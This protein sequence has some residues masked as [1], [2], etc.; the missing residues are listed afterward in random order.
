[1]TDSFATTVHMPGISPETV[2]ICLDDEDFRLPVPRPMALL[3][4][5]AAYAWR[6]LLPEGLVE[7]DTARMHERLRDPEDPMSWKRLHVVAQPLGLYLYGFPFFVAARALGTA[8]HYFTT[9]RMWSLCNIAIDLHRASA[10]DWCAAA[11]TWLS[12]QGGGKEEQRKAMWAELT[13]P[14]VL[15]MEA[16]GV[17]PDWLT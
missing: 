9:F 4:I 7:T 16:P 11:V 17:S 2:V 14:G 13:T 3:D 6:R 12:Q 15:P 5:A 1:V 10:A 8:R